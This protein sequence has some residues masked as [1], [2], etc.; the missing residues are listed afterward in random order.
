MLVV[1]K[2][3]KRVRG[4]VAVCRRGVNCLCVP[5]CYARP[6][7][8]A[9]ELVPYEE[10]IVILRDAIIPGHQ[11]AI[12]HLMLPISGSIA[13]GSLSATYV[14]CKC[15]IFAG[16]CHNALS[17]TFAFE[18]CAKVTIVSYTHLSMV[19]RHCGVGGGSSNQPEIFQH[20]PPYYYNEARGVRERWLFLLWAAVT[21]CQTTWSTL[22][23]C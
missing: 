22:R 7:G 16:L 10:Y 14:Y 21:L 11:Y 20:I 9:E 4:H 2:K 3:G 8:Y 5:R 17:R 1:V 23:Q 12:R 15:M 18:L 13:S 19:L 6:A